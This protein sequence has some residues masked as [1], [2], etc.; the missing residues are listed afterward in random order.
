MW[1]TLLLSLGAASFAPAATAN[2]VVDPAPFVS[3]DDPKDLP[4]KREEVENLIDELKGHAKEKGK[5]DLQAIAVIDRMTQEFEKSGLK[6]RGSIAKEIGNLLK[7]RRKEIDGVLDNK[8]FLAAAE[9]LSQM[10]PES[11]K[12][13]Q[14]WI[15]HKSH[16]K[17]LDLQATLIR[18]LGKTKDEKGVKTLLDILSHHE[19]VLQA[20]AGDALGNYAHL[21][22]KE[23]KDIFKD[24]LQTLT[25]VYN[26]MQGDG[27][28]I[29]ARERYDVIAAPMITTL[30]VL[31]GHDERQPNGWTR[32]WN[33]N[34]KANWDKED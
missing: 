22:Q 7:Q 27:Q 24:I 21:D 12:I 23:R 31:S 1:N 16:K 15:G 14:S 6:D 5:E 10:G 17:D 30:Q 34:K 11:V 20:A 4:D 28:N 13:L 8:L 3:Q 9:A 19:A 25:G 29:I 32:W 18:S 2:P 26:A 33:K